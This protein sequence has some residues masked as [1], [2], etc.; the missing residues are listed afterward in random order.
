MIFESRYVKMM[1]EQDDRSEAT[2]AIWKAYG[3]I[4]ER[5]KKTAG[6]RFCTRGKQMDA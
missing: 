2:M 6:N 4:D 1:S 3:E 5:E